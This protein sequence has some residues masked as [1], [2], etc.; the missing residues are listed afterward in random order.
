MARE[1]K[2]GCRGRQSD[3]EQEPRSHE[4][5]SLSLLISCAAKHGR[6]VRHDLKVTVRLCRMILSCM[7]PVWF[8]GCKSGAKWARSLISLED[9]VSPSGPLPA[10]RK[11]PMSS[12][13]TI[14]PSAMWQW[15]KAD[16]ERRRLLPPRC[17]GRVKS[18]GRQVLPGTAANHWFTPH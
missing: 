12:L 7:R 6:C 3:A 14:F 2:D 18:S 10:D 15:R 11:Q 5:R 17:R 9:T 1:R 13:G 8:V 16:S 4:S